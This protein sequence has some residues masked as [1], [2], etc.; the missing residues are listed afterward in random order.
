MNLTSMSAYKHE[1]QY[2]MSRNVFESKPLQYI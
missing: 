2:A 1:H